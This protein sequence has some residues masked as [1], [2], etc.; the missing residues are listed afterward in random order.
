[1]SHLRCSFVL[2]LLCASAAAPGIAQESV[3]VPF[4]LPTPEGWRTETL[5]FPLEF[6][7]ELEYEGLE[8]LR[9]SPGMFK[10]GSLD[11]WSYVFVW[12]V[13]EGTRFETEQLQTDL[14]QYFRGLTVAVAEAREFDPG[15]PDFEVQLEPIESS[16]P[17]HFQL[18]G[19]AATYDVFVTR[20]PIQ[21]KVR[22]DFVPCPSQGHVAA[23]FQLSPQPRNDNIWG[24]MDTM[25]QEFR[26]ER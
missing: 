11:F 18:E 8:E 20:K 15:E 7:P 25:R 1:M 23:F 5:P 17:E 22:I 13:P 10:E 4:H 12:W 21:L 24:L 2:L 16:T 9:F 14:E 3:E 6:A 26:C 19:T